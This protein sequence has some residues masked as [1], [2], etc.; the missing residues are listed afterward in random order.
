MSGK[1]SGLHKKIHDVSPYAYYVRVTISHKTKF[2]TQP[3]LFLKFGSWVVRAV[4]FGKKVVTFPDK[5][6][7]IC[8]F[9]YVADG[10]I[11]ILLPRIKVFSKKKVI[12]FLVKIH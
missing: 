5:F 10:R 11:R 8:Y 7:I 1:Y 9:F 6:E 3:L 12:V 4:T 2:H